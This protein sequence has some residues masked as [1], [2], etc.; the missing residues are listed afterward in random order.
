MFK[1]TRLDH[2]DKLDAVEV[3]EKAMLDIKAWMDQVCL[4]INES[5]TELIYFGG[6]RQ[7]EKCISHKIDVYGEDI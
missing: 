7:L 6:N 1:L 5:K 2:R 3:I 4:K